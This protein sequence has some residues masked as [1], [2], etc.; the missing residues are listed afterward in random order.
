MQKAAKLVDP[1][2]SEHDRQWRVAVDDP[3]RIHLEDLILVRLRQ[4]NH[5]V[6]VPDIEVIVKNL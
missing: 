6:W 2:S 4:L 1:D 3:A 5:E